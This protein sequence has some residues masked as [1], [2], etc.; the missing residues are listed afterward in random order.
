[1][2]LSSVSV[3]GQININAM[4][5]ADISRQCHQAT[6]SAM[7]RSAGFSEGLVFHHTIPPPGQDSGSSAATSEPD[8]LIGDEPLA[9]DA[10][11]C[12][13]D[14]KSTPAGPRSTSLFRD[15]HAKA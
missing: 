12:R 7:P 3:C 5:E 13:R 14:G 15:L 10:W 1:L 2:A 11:T 6:I 8:F 9:A 4:P